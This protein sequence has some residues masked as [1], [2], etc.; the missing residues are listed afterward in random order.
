MVSSLATLIVSSEVTQQIQNG[1]PRFWTSLIT[2]FQQKLKVSLSEL[3]SKLYTLKSEKTENNID[4]KT[5]K[6]LGKLEAICDN[7]LTRYQDHQ[8]PDVKKEKIYGSKSVNKVGEFSAG[9]SNS[10]V[11]S[12]FEVESNVTKELTQELEL[13]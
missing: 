8:V 5:L 6:L 7:N 11:V 12:K 10:A 2:S 4:Q 13:I 3:Q 1:I 9:T